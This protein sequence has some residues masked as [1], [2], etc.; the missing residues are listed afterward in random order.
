MRRRRIMR[1]LAVLTLIAL[2]LEGQAQQPAS[3][4]DRQ[5]IGR[6]REQE[7]ATFSS[8][9]VEKLLGLLTGDVVVMPPNE[10]TVVGSEAARAWLR[11]MYEQ[12]KIE[13][14]YTST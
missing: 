13:A 6:L 7:I 2:A 9:D 4:A 14:T 3:E 8:G 11:R 10:P 1:K 12:F 5:A